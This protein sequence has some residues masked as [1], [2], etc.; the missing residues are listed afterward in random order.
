MEVASVTASDP[1]GRLSAASKQREVKL[2]DY[3]NSLIGG[4]L[5]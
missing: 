4:V 1:S 2:T 3:W 5:E